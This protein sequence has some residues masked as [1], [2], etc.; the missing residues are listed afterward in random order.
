MN[1]NAKTNNLWVKFNSLPK[2]ARYSLFCL[3]LLI[4]VLYSKDFVMDFGSG[5]RDGFLN[6]PP[7]I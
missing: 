7:K 5:F 1:V 6:L 3:T 2:W 4:V